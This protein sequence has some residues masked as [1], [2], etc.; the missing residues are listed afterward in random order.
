[1]RRIPNPTKKQPEPPL[2]HQTA[3]ANGASPAAAPI[4]TGGLLQKN[5]HV[6][7]V[8]KRAQESAEA[9]KWDDDFAFDETSSKISSFSKEPA[10]DAA[11][12]NHAHATM[13]QTKDPP[14]S[15]K[16]TARLKG[17]PEDYSDL[18]GDEDNLDLEAKFSN[19]KVSC[20]DIG[21]ADR[22]DA[23]RVGSA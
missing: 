17:I 8:L 18:A 7:D 6:S 5:K 16:G 10:D 14:K 1:M 12:A 2:P 21:R 23:T 13:R 22:R 19:L 4:T 3:P 9:E 15:N 20:A 11:S